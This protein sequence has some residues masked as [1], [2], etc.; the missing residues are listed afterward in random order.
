MSEEGKGLLFAY[1]PFTQEMPLPGVLSRLTGEDRL[2]PMPGEYPRLGGPSGG[3][4]EPTGVFDDVSHGIAPEFGH[5]PGFNRLNSGFS[6]GDT[7]EH[8]FGLVMEETL[9]RYV[10]NGPEV[11]VF[12]YRD[13][14]QPPGSGTVPG[15]TVVVPY[16]EPAV[17]RCYNAL[18][19]D[20]GTSDDGQ[21]NSTGHAHESSIHLHGGHNTAHSDGYPDF[22]TLAGESRDYW[23]TNCGPQETNP[24]TLIAPVDGD[25]FDTAW[26]P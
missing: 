8:E 10:P 16:R 18:T 19:A 21:V 12:T 4:M 26:I 15:P 20:R 13:V 2:D 25:N 23:Y 14:T 7:H 17:V 6:V 3:P 5:F 24:D 11:P 1:E 22:Y 9:H